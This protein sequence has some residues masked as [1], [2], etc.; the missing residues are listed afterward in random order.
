MSA[1]ATLQIPRRS[2]PARL[3][4]PRPTRRDARSTG[5]RLPGANMSR[6]GLALAPVVVGLLAGSVALAQTPA[7]QTPAEQTPSAQAPTASKAKPTTTPA[8]SSGAPSRYL[9]NRFAGRA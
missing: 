7:A 4:A 2:A 9:P 3:R 1:H 6:T 5:F 8:K